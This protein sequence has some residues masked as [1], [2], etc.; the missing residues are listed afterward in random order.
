MSVGQQVHQG[1]Y[2]VAL[3][4]AGAPVIAEMPADL[5]DEAVDPGPLP[6][7]R[8]IS[9][10]TGSR[11]TGDV[12]ALLVRACRYVVLVPLVFRV[13]VIPVLFLMV[14]AG[15]RSAVLP[16]GLLAAFAV[17][18]NVLALVLVLRV[19]G[20]RDSVARLLL[21]LDLIVGFG[22]NLVAALVVQ[23]PGYAQV[24]RMTWSYLVGSVALFTLTR[25]VFAGGVV[26]VASVP[27]HVLLTTVGGHRPVASPVADVL[28][29][30]STLI[31]ALVTAMVVLILIGLGTR[32]ALGVGVRRGRRAEH[33]RAQRTI[34]DTVLQTLEAMALSPVTEPAD[35]PGALAQL[36]ELRGV[37][38]AQAM[39]LRRG[40]SEPVEQPATTGLG[41]DLAGVAAEMAR[42]G[43]RARLVFTE[44]DD[45]LLSEVRRRAVR[46]AVREA[47]RNTMKHAGTD[48]VVLRVEQRDGGIAVIARDHGT[49][50]SDADRPA[51]FGISNS[52]TARLADVGGSSTVE[53]EPGRGTRV[54][55]WVPL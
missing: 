46:D 36:T 38:R 44:V 25:G 22:V 50:F 11:G 8:R 28:D 31:P 40:L 41:E 6:G 47:M 20:F 9:M 13:V 21:G 43:L 29:D 17:A 35:L 5:P 24:E 48:E 14:L 34:H 16:G 49:G 19:R 2:L 10:M 32:L 15:A 37:A 52:I 3:L 4:R 27:V 55:L 26:I 33:A 23:D 51:G 53:S 54:T 1:G 18:V 7:W 30:V 12:D 39:Q 45:G 42:E